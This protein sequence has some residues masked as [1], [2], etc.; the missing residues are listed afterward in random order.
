MTREE[1]IEEV[2]KVFEPAFANYI[3]TALTEGATVSDIQRRWGRAYEAGVKDGLEQEPNTWSL[4][5]AREDFMYDVYNTLDFLPTNEEANQIIDSFDRVTS[6]IKQ[7]PRWIPVS[8]KLPE[9]NRAVLTYIDT[10]A[11]KTYCLANWNDVREAWEEW[12]GY[13]LIEKDKYYKVIA[14]M[15]LPEP[16]KAESE[17]KE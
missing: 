7:E 5:D 15:P 13:D 3:I 17:D 16:Y 1:A 12:I 8:E 9:A 14:W 11:T 2:N 4:D 6:S 10:G